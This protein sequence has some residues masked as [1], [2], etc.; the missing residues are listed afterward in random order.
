[1][2]QFKHMVLIQ[3]IGNNDGRH[4]FLDF[5]TKLNKLINH[6]ILIKYLLQIHTGNKIKYFVGVIWKHS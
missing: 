5:R 2:L 3:I 1:M 6:G 4:F